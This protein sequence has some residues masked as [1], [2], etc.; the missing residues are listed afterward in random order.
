M[1]LDLKI[2]QTL[3]SKNIQKHKQ[4]IYRAIWSPNGKYIAAA[5]SIGNIYLWNLKSGEIIQ[6]IECSNERILSIAW[7][8]D[9]KYIAIGGSNR[10]IQ[11]WNIKEVNLEQ[12]L[13]GHSDWIRD[14]AWSP[15]GTQIVSCSS[16]QGVWLWATGTGQPL[17][18]FEGHTNWVKGLAWS[19]DGNFIVS[20][21]DDGTVRLWDARALKCINILTNKGTSGSIYSVDWSEDSLLIAGASSDKTIKIWDGKTYEHII[22]LEGHTSAISN[23]CFS[24]NNG[25]LASIS[26][27]GVIRIWECQFWKEI[28]SISGS[29]HGSL[30][31]PS[32][33][34]F[35]PNSLFLATPTQEGSA[36]SIWS[37]EYKS[38]DISSDFVNNQA[39]FNKSNTYYINAKAVLVGES[40]V[41]KSGLGIRIAEK[42][43]RTTESTHG[44][45]FW[46]IPVSK[47]SNLAQ[48]QED[49]NAELTLWDLAGQPDYHLIHQLFLDDTDVA[50]L[51]FDCSNTDDPFRGIP[52][53]AKVLKN[54]SN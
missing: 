5:S 11:I 15:N 24:K 22:T 34:A 35:H 10:I 16:D 23:I 39:N 37:L 36:I 51:L 54:S 30:S 21:S 20:G 18:R 19:P 47:Q 27:D 25:F 45:Q 12:E 4:S 52:Y 42:E 29:V 38:T 17:C 28:A 53:W 46:Q 2:F 8:P 33:L 50:L 48:N 9:G 1:I 31:W 44:A 3:G 14:I 41:G 40:G 13:I 6:T 32:V 26:V 7:S 43:F 49:I